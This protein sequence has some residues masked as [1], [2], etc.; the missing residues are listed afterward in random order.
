MWHLI[1]NATIAIRQIYSVW[2]AIFWFSKEKKKHDIF[3]IK[4]SL[5]LL[6]SQIYIYIFYL[7]MDLKVLV[8]K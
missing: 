7:A 2:S 1:A 3:L 4:K 5:L 6:V 8:Y